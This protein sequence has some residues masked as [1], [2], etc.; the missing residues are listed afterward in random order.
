MTCNLTSLDA[1]YQAFDSL[2]VEGGW[3]R[4]APALWAEPRKNFV[5]FRWRYTDVKPI[6]DAAG[7]LVDHTMADRRNLT[8]T[9]PVEGNLYA[10]VRSM[11]AAYQ[12]I[13]PGETA[14]A[15]R[16]TPNAL[17][18]ILE[19]KGTYTVVNGTRVE[20]RPGDVLLTPSWAWHSHSSN[21]E[22]DCYWVDILDVPLVHLLEGMF[23]ERHPEKLESD[24]IDADTSPIAFRWEDS[25]AALKDA[26]APLNGMAQQEIELGSPAL[27]TIALH[28]QRLDAGF[29]SP[30]YRTTSNS[31]FTVVQGSGRTCID[32]EV[33]EWSMGDVIAV[34][35]WRTY[36]HEADTES[37]FVRASDE[38]VMR[39]VDML[40]DEV[41]TNK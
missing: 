5:P 26:G 24:V 6:L 19:G 4:K 32:G 9:N 35:A 15:H 11:V 16:H 22:E 30:Q 14:D 28:V 8:M 38:P 10:T 36:H 7:H 27:K 17:R 25:V 37:F 33:F 18:I 1:L 20:M 39:A 3:H 21:G 23:F 34:P 40:R 2:S 29:Q 41:L 13:K 31:I 12:L